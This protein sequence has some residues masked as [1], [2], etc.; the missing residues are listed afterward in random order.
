VAARAREQQLLDWPTAL[1]GLLASAHPEVVIDLLGANDLRSMVAASK[2][3]YGGTPAWNAQYGVRVT[4]VI[5]KIIRAGSHLLWIG[6]PEMQTA[7]INAGT[8][9]IDAVFR[10]VVA[11]CHGEAAYLSAAVLAPDGNFSFGVT[12]PTG[13]AVQVRTPDGVHLM[14][15]A[16][17]LLAAAAAEALAD[18]WGMQVTG[19]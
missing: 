18:D 8:A 4:A 14:A 3:L 9:R 15:S 10:R 7:F 16:A 17:G 2:I 6:D 19:Q 1:A 5:S 13:Q 11:H 12:G